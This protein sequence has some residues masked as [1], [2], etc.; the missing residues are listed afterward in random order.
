MSV[1]PEV[2]SSGHLPALATAA[3][4]TKNILPKKRCRKASLKEICDKDR[5]PPKLIAY[6]STN[7]ERKCSPFSTENRLKI[8]NEFW[9]MKYESR[10]HWLIQAHIVTYKLQ[11]SRYSRAHAPNV[12]YLPRELSF[13]Q[14]HEDCKQKYLDQKCGVETYRNTL[15]SMNISFCMPTNERCPTCL[16]YEMS[17]ENI[18]EDEKKSWQQHVQQAMEARK[19]SHS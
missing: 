7:C 12:W 18:G 1:C 10:R 11:V 19:W 3:A 4:S 13:A 8:W 14:M 17:K 6:S 2:S 15:R 5:H 9:S 16:R